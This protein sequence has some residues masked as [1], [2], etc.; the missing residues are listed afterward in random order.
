MLNAIGE[1]GRKFVIGLVNRWIR[2]PENA[3]LDLCNDCSCAGFGGCEVCVGESFPA[4]DAAFF[5]CLTEVEVGNGWA[6][7]ALFLFCEDIEWQL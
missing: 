7:V 2:R 4:Y 5:E 1:E 6:L 3:G